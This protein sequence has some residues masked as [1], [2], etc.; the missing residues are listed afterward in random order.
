[1][2]ARRES[3]PVVTDLSVFRDLRSAD[4][5]LAFYTSRDAEKTWKRLVSVSKTRTALP[6]LLIE[7]SLLMPP[8]YVGRTNCLTRRYSEHVRNSNGNFHRRFTRHTAALG[9]AL[10]VSDPPLRLP[11]DRKSVRQVPQ[12]HRRRTDRPH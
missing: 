1:M 2:A 3:V 5:R 10:P 7:A 11:P 12:S 9:I 8:L 6:H 4:G